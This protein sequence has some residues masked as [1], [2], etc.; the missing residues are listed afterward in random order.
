MALRWD[1]FPHDRLRLAIYAR[2]RVNAVERADGDSL[3]HILQ[4][5]LHKQNSK[6]HRRFVELEARDLV[7]HLRAT[8]DLYWEYV[9]QHKCRPIIEAQWVVLRCA[10]FPT[11]IAL[12]RASVIRY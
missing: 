11:A 8:R 5:R 1:D 12:L 10:V 2:L 6:D 4:R 3:R 9:E 7:E